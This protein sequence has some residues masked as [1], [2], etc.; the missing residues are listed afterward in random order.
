MPNVKSAE[1]RVRTNEKRRLRNR[2]AK[3]ALKTVLKRVAATAQS[4]DAD[5]LKAAAQTAMRVIGRTKSKGII[6]RRRAA[7]LQSRVQKKLNK[8]LAASAT[9][10]APT[11]SAP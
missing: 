1:K 9:T 4:A 7:R 2:A 3:A 10:P 11:P 6:N 8:A 5:A